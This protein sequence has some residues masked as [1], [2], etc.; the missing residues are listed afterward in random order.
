M[1]KAPSG[2]AEAVKAADERR[3]AL[4]VGEEIISLGDGELDRLLKALL[5]LRQ[6]D[7]DTVREQIMALR[8]IGGVIRLAPTEAQLA[9]LEVALGAV[10]D[11]E[12]KL[13]PRLLRLTAG[14]TDEIVAA[15]ESR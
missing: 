15:G 10:A 1:T 11:E 3:T 8:L 4:A 13:G 2:A 9:A 12:P 5:G 7:A 6:G 14:R